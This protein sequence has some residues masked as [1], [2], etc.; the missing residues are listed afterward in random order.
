MDNNR[1]WRGMSG[2]MLAL[3]LFAGAEQASAIE[4]AE[5]GQ[6]VVTGEPS[7]VGPPWNHRSS[8]RVPGTETDFV[9]GGYLKFDALYDTDYDLGDVTNPLAVRSEA[10]RTDGRTTFHAKESRLNVR[11]STA[12]GVGQLSTYVEAHFLPAGDFSLRHA[13]GEIGPWLV[14]RSWSNFMSFVG[15]PRSLKLGTPTGHPFRRQAQAR[16]TAALGGDGRFSLSLEEPTT[17]VA[18]AAAPAETPMPDV[19][20]RYEHGRWFALAG[21]AR[22][23]E[24]RDGAGTEG[25]S[26]TAFGVNSQLAL[27]LGGATRL[28]GMAMYGEGLGDYLGPP[29]ANPAGMPDVYLDGG[30]LE[31]VELWSASLALEHQWSSSWTST[32]SYT[33]ASQDIPG[34][35]G[36]FAEDVDYAFAGLYWD[37][38]PRLTLG[39]EYQ[40]TE[41]TDND[42]VNRDASRVQSSAIVQ[43]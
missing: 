31:A 13:Y 21:V 29:V 16:Y 14:G 25:D 33:R 20:A 10:N 34:R 5:A 41:V 17:I 28:K 2:C 7:R 12:T 8:W 3:L 30:E 22:R 27:P 32:L 36:T 38:M 6:P 37:P 39:V 19:T 42:G 43:F 9:I 4:V 40:Y 11:T 24:T 18:N 15:A 26:V 23:L 1:R 35:V